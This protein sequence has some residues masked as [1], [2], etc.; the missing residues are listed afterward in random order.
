M[1]IKIDVL[2]DTQEEPVLYRGTLFEYYLAKTNSLDKII[3][4]NAMRRGLNNVESNEFHEFNSDLFIIENKH[5][6]N[7][8]IKYYYAEE[9]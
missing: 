1:F 2:V 8:N 4:T 9:N 5:I 3:I 7:I 6:K